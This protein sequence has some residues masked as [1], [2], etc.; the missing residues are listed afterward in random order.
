MDLKNFTIQQIHDKIATMP[1]KKKFPQLYKDYFLYTNGDTTRVAVVDLLNWKKIADIPLLKNDNYAFEFGTSRNNKTIIYKNALLVIQPDTCLHV[2]EFGKNRNLTQTAKFAIRSLAGEYKA[3][4]AKL[5]FFKGEVFLYNKTKNI[6]MDLRV[7]EPPSVHSFETKSDISQ[8]LINTRD[9]FIA[10]DASNIFQID[11]NLLGVKLGNYYYSVKRNIAI[12]NDR[13]NK[14]LIFYQP[15][16]RK[17]LGFYPYQ[18][19]RYFR[20]YYQ[21]NHVYFVRNGH[22]KSLDIDAFIRRNPLHIANIYDYIAQSYYELGDYDNAM[23]ISGKVLTEFQPNSA[24]SIILQGKTFFRREEYSRAADCFL[25]AFSLLPEDNANKIA[26]E[27][28]LFNSGLYI[29]SRNVDLAEGHRLLEVLRDGILFTDSKWF[30][31]NELVKLDLE[32][33]DIIWKYS[34]LYHF[35]GLAL[36][37]RMLAYSECKSPSGSCSYGLLNL[38]KKEEEMRLPSKTDFRIEPQ[39]YKY[40]DSSMIAYFRKSDYNPSRLE[41]IDIKKKSV[42]KIFD[43][44]ELI[45]D[46]FIYDNTVC[47]F[48]PAMF[49]F[50]DTESNKLSSRKYDFKEN[51]NGTIFQILNVSHGRIYVSTTKNEIFEG[52]WGD[53]RFSRMAK[54]S[55]IFPGIAYSTNN[56]IVIFAKSGNISLQYENAANIKDISIQG[57]K[58]YLL[59]PDYITCLENKKMTERYPLLWTAINF[60]IQG[61]RAYVLSSAGKIYAVDLN[62]RPNKLKKDLILS[63]N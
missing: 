44:N 53:L 40:S 20:F 45:S 42:Q 58:I 56:K 13:G 21:N 19:K 60:R 10:S 33:G 43:S 15:A 57:S 35:K 62:W 5:D 17:L 6:L 51:R 24:P 54:A 16:T 48:T 23:D 27:N 9:F 22:F 11:K 30:R 3:I 12:L 47:F 55:K 31:K 36:T 25:K 61:D 63:L 46:P 8:I 26:I 32:T 29:W 59:E 34:Y 14:R 7:D 38:D 18:S 28:D 2:Y 37:P 50:Y 52:R 49:Y 1:G 39:F 41:F 4:E